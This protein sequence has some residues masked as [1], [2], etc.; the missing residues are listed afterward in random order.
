MRGEGLGPAK[1]LCPSTGDCLVK[2]VGVGGLV[3]RFV[4]GRNRG[5]LEGKLGKQ[6][7]YEM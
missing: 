1:D 7:T 3:N 2:E 4:G 6:R 5:F